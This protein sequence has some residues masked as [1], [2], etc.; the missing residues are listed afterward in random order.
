MFQRFLFFQWRWK[1]YSSRVDYSSLLDNFSYLQTMLLYKSLPFWFFHLIWF[2]DNWSY[3]SSCT[4]HD[5]LILKSFILTCQ[6]SK[7]V[8]QLNFSA[9]CYKVVIVQAQKNSRL[10]AKT[11]TT[12]SWSKWW[13]LG[14]SRESIAKVNNKA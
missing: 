5:G 4:H 11:L 12:T 2:L 7:F 10:L 14:C 9:S 6:W 1:V 13:K 3:Q 8:F